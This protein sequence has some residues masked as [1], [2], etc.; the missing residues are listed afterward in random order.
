VCNWNHKLFC[1][2]LV[3][4][5]L[6]AVHM[7]MLIN[8]WIKWNTSLSAASASYFGHTNL[9]WLFIF[10]KSLLLHCTATGIF[11]LHKKNLPIK[12]THKH[13]Q[14]REELPADV[15]NARGVASVN[16]LVCVYPHITHI[17]IL[18]TAS[19]KLPIQHFSCT[20]PTK[21][22]LLPHSFQTVV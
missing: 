12:K 13:T 19:E 5:N 7:N 16:I 1:C 11:C 10:Y 9:L 3:H 8:A 15:A 22:K 14:T 6:L 18:M 17:H 20:I 4:C 21:Q 2:L